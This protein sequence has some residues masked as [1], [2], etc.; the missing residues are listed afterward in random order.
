MGA[1]F[2]ATLRWR[3]LPQWHPPHPGSDG[4]LNEKGVCC[5]MLALDMVGTFLLAI[6]LAARPQAYQP[7]RSGSSGIAKRSQIPVKIR[8]S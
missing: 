1:A 7:G 6:L 4:G 2:P 8:K 3:R 5:C